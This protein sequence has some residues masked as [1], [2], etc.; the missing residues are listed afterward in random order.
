MPEDKKEACP[1]C[2]IGEDRIVIQ[3]EKAIAIRD[4]FPV[5]PG[6]TLVVSRRHTADWFD[7]SRE[8]R[9]A[10][11]DLVEQVKMALD[12]EINL[13]ATTSASIWERPRA[14]P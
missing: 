5:N 11:I 3:N 12:S 1:F 6:H 8:E 7:A 10:I 2:D 9:A 14:R 13:R 4:N